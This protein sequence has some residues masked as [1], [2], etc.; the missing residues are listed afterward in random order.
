MRKKNIGLFTAILEND[1]CQAV[2]QGATKAAKENDVNLI[3]FPMDIINSYYGDSELNRYQYQYHVM[4]SFMKAKELDGLLI[5]YGVIT[6]LL[7][8]EEKRNFLAE[9]EGLPVVL[10]ADQ[11][12]GFDSITVDNSTGL[13]QVIDHLVLDHQYKKIALLSG[14]MENVDG[15]ERYQIFRKR[16][17]HHKLYLGEEWVIKGDFSP[18]IEDKL[19]GFVQEHP[20]V[21]AI[22]C[23]NDGMAI[24]AM[25]ALRRIGR[26][27]G[28]DIFITGFDDVV[29]GFLSTPALTTVKADPEELAYHALQKLCGMEDFQGNLS[30]A[31]QIVR[32]ESC[33]CCGFTPN[34]YW[35]QRLGVVD[36]WREDAI[37][38]SKDAENVRRLVRELSTVTREMVFGRSSEKERYE[39][40]LDSLKRLQFDSCRMYLYDNF[41]EL[42]RDEK[43]ISPESVNLVAFYNTLDS[44][45]VCFE[46]QE[47]KIS[48]MDLIS[49]LIPEDE[50]RHEVVVLPL[51]FARNQIG[52]FSADCNPKRF[53]SVQD[54]VGHI[55]NTLFMIAMKEEQE[56]MKNDLEKANR[57]KSQFLANMSH[58]IRTPINA[59]IGF[60]EMILRENQDHTLGEYAKDVSV[61]ADALLALVND[62]LDFSKIEAGKMTLVEA[63][64]SLADLLNRVIGMLTGRAEK[65][66]LA[67]FLKTE[68]VFPKV[69]TGD[70]GRIQQILLNL[71]TNAIK[72]TEYGTVTLKVRSETKENGVLLDFSI[73]DTGIGIKQEDMERLYLEFE[74]I[75]EKRNRNIEGTGLGINIVTGLLRMMNSKLEVRSTYGKGS[76]FSFKLHQQIAQNQELETSGDAKKTQEALS[77]HK[78]GARVLLVDD[79]IM[80]RRVICSLL[81]NSGMVIHQAE[82]GKQCIELMRKNTY[83]LILLDHMMPDMDGVETLQEMLAERLLDIHKTPVIALT[84]NAVEGAKEVYLTRGFTDYLSKPVRYTDLCAMLAKHLGE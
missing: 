21:E 44:E 41:I 20:E 47:C 28:K 42:K 22:V 15:S 19:I 54:M 10:I 31:T 17:E 30:I 7:N 81:K 5:E 58:E 53:I 68:G 40:V 55:S 46:K 65:K 34:P 9:A 77:F 82:G 11:A 75:E 6:S 71:L 13:I 4:S 67:L 66:G 14:P 39:F 35:M 43:W 3:V 83:D 84:A 38:H 73:I 61:A 1:F 49:N 74:R 8:A 63:D 36:H 60:N 57:Y 45:N 59:I 33:G 16:M 51:F 52:I 70:A 23:A 18:N 78:E 56:R 79:N 50:K 72:Y 32:R 24:G 76:E 2:L 48:T 69:L 26:E 12:E 37:Q 25:S 29:G 64:Y 62:I 27:P 80:N